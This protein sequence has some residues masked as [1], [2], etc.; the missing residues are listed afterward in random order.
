MRKI[1]GAAGLLLAV[2]LLAMA[3]R[4]TSSTL[5]VDAQKSLIRWKG[6]K[7]GGLGKHEGT[8]K[9][10]TGELM[11]ENGKL[12]DARFT[13]D[14][15]S[16]DITDIPA[17]EKVARQKLRTHLLHED[18][19]YAAKHPTAS[20]VMTKC[21]FK[22]DN[23]Y[24]LTG[25][26]TLRGQTKPVS[27][28]AAFATLTAQRVAAEARLTIDRQRWGVAYRGSKLTND[29]VDDDIALIIRLQTKAQ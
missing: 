13:I 12:T 3:P 14:M 1:Q 18:F 20:F 23:L 25:N 22:E 2:L 8:L 17:E 4:P 15:N 28:D 29:L 6:T 27:F 11:V 7:F 9:I 26:L 5:Q 10:S 24:T 21:E 19:F 16:L